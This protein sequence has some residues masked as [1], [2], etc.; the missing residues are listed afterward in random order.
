MAPDSEPLIRDISD[1]ARWVAVYRA[2]EG[3]RED[4][5]FRDPFARRLAGPR[6][7]RI[8]DAMPFGSRHAWSWTM[9]TYL[10]DQLIL[11]QVHYG[12]DT[13]LN[14]GCGLDS[15]PYRMQLPSSLR[16]IEVD[17]P[18]ILHQKQSILERET[19]TCHLD[20]IG[21][22]ISNVEERRTLFAE[23]GRRSR[24]AL[25][26]TEGVMIYMTTDE[27]IALARDLANVSSFRAWV[28]DLASPGLLRLVRKR[29]GPQL[30]QAGLELRF[31][32]QEGPHFFA[33]Y[34]WTSKEVH[35]LLKTAA[36]L[37]RLSFFMQLLAMLPQSGKPPGSRPWSGVCLLAR[38]N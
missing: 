25:I 15:R 24:N 11:K 38:Q 2:S 13:I 7:E 17:L 16:W 20:S 18:E 26:V 33:N 8:A 30:K 1:T 10:I 6:G 32:P 35:S 37:R 19:P 36:R 34:G 31:A 22:D 4:A 5:L 9:R 12:T 27:V 21:L 14:L 3:E 29:L 28:L 23:I